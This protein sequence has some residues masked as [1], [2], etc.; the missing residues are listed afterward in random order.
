MTVSPKDRQRDTGA[1]DVAAAAP[2]PSRPAP[3]LYGREAEVARI[4]SLLDGARASRS[5]VL[6]LRGAAGAGKSALL[7][8]TRERAADMR[9]L[10]S[11]GIESEAELPFAALH[12]LVRPILPRI[13]M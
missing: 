2:A 4:D 5:G 10:A 3:V 1:R 12:Q 13:E 9:L 11:S 7:E 6:V 8:W